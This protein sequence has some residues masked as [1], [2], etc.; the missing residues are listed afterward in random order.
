MD[1][2]SDNYNENQSSCYFLDLRNSTLI[3]REISLTDDKK[4]N[5]SSEKLKIHAELMF[6]IHEEFLGALK[7]AD[8]TECYYNDTGD[9]HFCLL[10]NKTHAW[11]ALG[12]ACSLAIYLDKKLAEYN[13]NHLKPWGDE[14]DQKLSIAFGMGLH[15]G[16]SLV[17]NHEK[18]KRQFALGIVLNSAARIESYTKNFY[19][20]PLLFTKNFVDL[21]EAQHE[22]TEKQSKKEWKHFKSK[23]KQVTNYNV[24]VKDSKSHGHLLFTVSKSDW[25]L[26]SI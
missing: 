4:T 11:T 15:S 26:F 23:I 3:T 21:L 18:L 8:V 16:G 9:G 25:K 1:L 10:W 22:S 13:K 17:F 2:I 20:L 14:I 6:K 19:D 24:D 7:K 5:K 12:I